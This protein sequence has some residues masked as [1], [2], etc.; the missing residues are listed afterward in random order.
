MCPTNTLE[1]NLSSHQTSDACHLLFFLAKL[2]REGS[3]AK[4]REPAAHGEGARASLIFL[5]PVTKK[6]ERHLRCGSVLPFICS[7]MLGRASASQEQV[8][9]PEFHPGLQKRGGILGWPFCPYV[10]A[11]HH[12]PSSTSCL[13][14]ICCPPSLGE[15]MP[16]RGRNLLLCR[17]AFLC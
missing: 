10:T 7:S 8:V 3:S 13:A 16:G 14:G 9:A 1:I 11:R 12:L 4:A 2:S 6:L 17:A 15:G 5:F